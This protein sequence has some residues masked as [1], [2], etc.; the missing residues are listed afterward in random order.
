MSYEYV[1]NRP[2]T[3]FLLRWRKEL[4]DEREACGT[5]HPHHRREGKNKPKLCHPER[6]PDFLLRR[7][8]Q[9]PRMRLSLR[10]AA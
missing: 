10:K 2:V 1:S 9:R 7:P 5:F 4:H 6:T 3:G 8:H